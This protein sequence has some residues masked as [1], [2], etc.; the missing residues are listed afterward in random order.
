M[1]NILADINPGLQATL[2]DEYSNEKAPSDG[3]VYY[4][5]RQYE[6]EA[7]AQFKK[8]WMARLSSNKEKR[9]RQ[10]SSHEDVCAAFDALLA[11]PAL[12]VHGM[13]LGSLPQALAL[14]CDEV[15]ISCLSL[16]VIDLNPYRKW[17]TA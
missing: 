9:F 6:R 7:N 12:L 13:K 2:I 10:L 17:S 1:Y 14:K 4:K 5:V 11:I 15:Y 8:R 3:E 16:S